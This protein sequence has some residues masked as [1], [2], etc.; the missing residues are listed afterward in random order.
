M[1]TALPLACLLPFQV[2]FPEANKHDY[3]ELSADLK[4]GLT[5]HFVSHFNQVFQLALEYDGPIAKTH[6]PS[7]TAAT[8]QPPPL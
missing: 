2:I 3:E 6:V 5:P 4:D 8:S 7:Q 1:L